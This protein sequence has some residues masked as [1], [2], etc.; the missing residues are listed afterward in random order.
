MNEKCASIYCNRKSVSWKAAPIDF[1]FV[2]YFTV[3]QDL[4]GSSTW[5]NLFLSTWVTQTLRNAFRITL[6]YASMLMCHWISILIF[7]FKYWSPLIHS[8]HDSAHLLS[9]MATKKDNFCLMLSYYSEIFVTSTEVVEPWFDTD[10]LNNRSKRLN[11]STDCRFRNNENNVL[12]TLTT[13]IITTS[14]W[15][16]NLCTRDLSS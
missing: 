13:W 7:R 2:I 1:V 5:R 16:T 12:N 14:R 10:T 6:N 15:W 9:T 4:C 11:E 8:F 3:L